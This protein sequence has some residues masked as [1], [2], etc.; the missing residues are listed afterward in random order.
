[1][2]R[3]DPHA[4]RKTLGRNLRRLRLERRMT[5][6]ELAHETGLRQ[7]WVSEAES[8]KNNVTLDNLQKVAVALRVRVVDLLDE[9][10]RR[11]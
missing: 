7:A 4:A 11:K 2:A 8:G 5:Q 6:E 3:L 10:M 1:M 9:T